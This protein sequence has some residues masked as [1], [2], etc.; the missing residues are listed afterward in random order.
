MAVVMMPMKVM[1]MMMSMVMTVTVMMMVIV[2]MTMA[3]KGE[4]CSG[5]GDTILEQHFASKNR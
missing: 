1:D 2:M 4:F 3:I 5:I